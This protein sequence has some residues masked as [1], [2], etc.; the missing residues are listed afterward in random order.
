MK[1]TI[2]S[3]LCMAASTIV[4]ADNVIVTETSTWKSVPVTV[5]ADKHTYVVTGTMP[6][7]DYYYS[8]PGYR[9]FSVQRE[10]AGVTPII[11]RS[12]VDNGTDIYCYPE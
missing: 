12:S 8:Y 7:G 11:Y 2:I 4:S 3:A 6:T 5:N 1:K 10:V 9:C